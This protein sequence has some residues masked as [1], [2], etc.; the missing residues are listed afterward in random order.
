MFKKQILR[1]LVE[2]HITLSHQSEISMS[3]TF[4]S[5]QDGVTGTSLP[6]HLKQ[7][8]DQTKYM[9]KIIFRHWTTNSMRFDPW[10]NSNR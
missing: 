1:I 8:E 2:K 9:E 6:F 5:C 10:E 7:L 3:G 4:T